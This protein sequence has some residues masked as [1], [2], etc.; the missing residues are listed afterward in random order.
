MNGVWFHFS[1]YLYWF[2]EK[3]SFVVMTFGDNCM[4]RSLYIYMMRNFFRNI[5]FSNDSSFIK[6]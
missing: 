5:N 4:M 1:S 2:T 6:I 3:S